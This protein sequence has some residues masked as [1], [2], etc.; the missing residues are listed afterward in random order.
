MTQSRGALLKTCSSVW[1]DVP[2]PR[3]TFPA[4]ISLVLPLLCLHGL[5]FGDFVPTLER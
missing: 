5:S 3:C 1:K 4:K 2:S